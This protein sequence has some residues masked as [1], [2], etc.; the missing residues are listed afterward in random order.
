[1][2]VPQGGQLL[3]TISVGAANAARGRTG[4]LLDDVAAQV[5]PFL[6]NLVLVWELEERIRRLDEQATQLRDARRRIVAVADRERRR[7][8]RNLHDGA[9]QQ[10]M[11]L[12]FRLGVARDVATKAP[13]RLPAVLA[14]LAVMAENA[15]TAI[16]ELGDGAGPRLLRE[17][18]LTQALLMHAAH[19]P[20]AAD[21]AV[22]H[23]KR[24][25]DEIEAAIYFSC[26]EALQNVL[27]HAAATRV[28]LAL[29]EAD[30]E[31]RF[32]I[33]DDGRGFD[34]QTCGAGSGLRNV[35]DRL[36][37]VGGSVAIESAPGRGTEVTGRVP[38]DS[39]ILEPA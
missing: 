20:V 24:Q 36:H 23:V 32:V 22:E 9:Q 31:L 5:A 6:R 28:R 14:E 4:S 15:V 30:G 37:A 1:V 7:L 34:P 39:R 35:T 12:I 33:S 16:V 11:G 27:R 19:L 2:L 3:G 8:E 38:L 13:E 18:G 26:L 29:E 10:L 21:V 17:H 25:P